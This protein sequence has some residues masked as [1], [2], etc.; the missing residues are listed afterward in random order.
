M[1][2]VSPASE[3]QAD[4]PGILVLVVSLSFSSLL[5]ALFLLPTS[6][7]PPRTLHQPRVRGKPPAPAAGAGAGMRRSVFVGGGTQRI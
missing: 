4:P 3:V 5:V 6:R 2:V 1:Y 7:A